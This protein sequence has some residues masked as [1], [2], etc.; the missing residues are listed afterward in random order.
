MCE[1]G[2]V[3]GEMKKKYESKME[4][5]DRRFRDKEVSEENRCCQLT[6]HSNGS[7]AL[8][9]VIRA[10]SFIICLFR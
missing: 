10:V 6:S 1:E 7:A 4:T 2:N 9:L 8:S 3:N 5:E